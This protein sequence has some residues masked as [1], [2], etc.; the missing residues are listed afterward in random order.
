[1]KVAVLGSG[2]R[3]NATLVET[4]A[5]RILVDAGFSGKDLDRRL[6]ELGRSAAEVDALL[7]T[8]EHSDHTRGAGI[9]ARRHDLPIYLGSGTREACAELFRGG[10]D[11]REYRPAHPF[12]IG[13]IRVEPFLTAHDAAD[14]VSVTLVGAECGSRVGMA[15]DLGRPTAQVRHAL[16]GCH[17]LVL[18]ANHDEVLLY[19]APYP[20]RTKARIRSS[21]GH[22]SNATA[23][24]LAEELLHE[25]LKGV[26]LAHLSQEANRPELARQEVNRTL[27]AAGYMGFVTVAPQDEPTHLIDVA[28]LRRSA[29]EP[30][31]LKLF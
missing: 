18:E 11:L 28:E 1:M 15:T 2:S 12:E 6:A 16:A 10:E 14:P 24:C 21:H 5:T 20:A 30:D 3:G 9:F 4:D 13:D 7:L 31:Q 26:I 22:L 19:D 29:T 27:R 25:G 17:L 8:H 23:A